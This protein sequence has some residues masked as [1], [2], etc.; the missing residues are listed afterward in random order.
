MTDLWLPSDEEIALMTDDERHEVSE[1]LYSLRKEEDEEWLPQ[2]KQ[3]LAFKLAARADET[4]YGGAAGGGKTEWLIRYLL[5]QMLEFPF[6]RGVAFR[7][8]FPSLELTL[9]PR[10][11]MVYPR[12]G[13]R[14]NANE[15]SW[16]FP[17][18]SVLNLGSLPTIQ[19]VVKYQGTEYGVI[20]FEEITEFEEKMVD[21]M[22]V[23]LRPPGPGI[24]SHLIA[25][26]NPGGRGHKWVKRRWVKPKPEDYVGEQPP[27][28]YEVWKPKPTEEHPEPLSR[29]FVPATLEDNPILESR[30]PTYRN[31]IRA[32]RN[33][34]KALALAMEHGDWD[35]IDA[36]EG[37][38]WKQSDLDG[39]RV[40]PKWYRLNVT[41]AARVLA[42]DPSD[43]NEDGK[44]DA[45]GVAV[46]ALGMDG[47]GYVEWTDAWRATPDTLAKK[48]VQLAAEKDCDA[49]VIERNHGGKW[50]K[51]VVQSKDRYAVIKTVWASDGKVTRA[52]PIA[53]LFA[54]DEELAEQGMEYRIR[55]VGTAHEQF[56]DQATTF[57]AAPGEPSPDVMDAVVWGGT[58]L[59]LA[60]RVGESGEYQDDR[61][62]GRR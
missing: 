22:E 41:V 52:R 12:Y 61:L 62:R 15:H 19:D 35:A 60:P 50:L 18:G 39:G 21:Q 25:T 59:L 57:T 37:A 5:Q 8:F 33:T 51:T 24:R 7:R 27:L 44:G 4:L 29:V 20:A 49:V 40:D 53:A 10:T 45:Y 23:R 28:P 36:V 30:D 26:C 34:D 6:N 43:G 58:Y 46:I 32:L 55:M 47:V 17:N 38:L 13:G 3:E 16:R 11:L 2:P 1:L 31:K 42:V 9:I 56:E 14:Y 54:R 48:T